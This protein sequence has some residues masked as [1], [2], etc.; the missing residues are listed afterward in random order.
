MIKK[1]Q[2]ILVA[3]T[4]I[5]VIFLAS[6]S[7]KAETVETHNAILASINL[8]PD[9]LTKSF[10]TGLGYQYNFSNTLFLRV[11]VGMDYNRNVTTKPKY[12]EKD[13]ILTEFSY[14]FTPGLKYM[15]TNSNKNAVYIGVETI[16]HH[17]DYLLENDGFKSNTTEITK[18]T[19][20]AGIF[21][22]LDI[23]ILKRTYLSLEWG[24]NLTSTTGKVQYNQAG[25]TQTDDLPQITDFAIRAKNI[26]AMLSYYF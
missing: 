1:E 12:A 3:I 8:K 21:F 11:I 22:G 7:L 19:F 14:S 15:I 18:N 20:G 17:N 16:L 2:I 5:L 10:K 26:I 23:Y 24:F 9:T 25:N 13:K 6:F 4:K